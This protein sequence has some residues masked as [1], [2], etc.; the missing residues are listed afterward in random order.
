[1]PRARSP[2]GWLRDSDRLRGHDRSHGQFR[3]LVGDHSPFRFSFKRPWRKKDTVEKSLITGA[4]SCFP[5]PQVSWYPS[6]PLFTEC[7]ISSG[8]FTT[9]L[10]INRDMAGPGGIP[11]S[12]LWSNLQDMVTT[13]PLLFLAMLASLLIS[14]F[15]FLQRDSRTRNRARK[16]AAC[17]H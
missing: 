6:F 11:I 4:S 9:S 1:M 13:A 16:M 14:L 17:G 2:I 5:V 3:T 15:I 12:L 10:V 8:L 7:R